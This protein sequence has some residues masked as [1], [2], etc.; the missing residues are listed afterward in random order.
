MNFLVAAN[1]KYMHPLRVMLTSLLC[2]NKGEN[3]NIYF[4]YNNVCKNSVASLKKYIEKNFDCNF[5]P[6]LIHEE[7]FNEFPISHH[8]SIETY[9]R[10]LAQDIVPQSEDRV[11]WLDADMIVRKPLNEFYYQDFEGKSLVACKSINTDPQA[12]LD[13]LGC[14]QGAVYFNAGIILFNLN[15]LRGITLQDYYKFYEHNKEKIRWLDQDILN[16]IYALDVKIADYRI[17]NMQFFS[18]PVPIEDQ[19]T[20]ESMSAVLHYIGNKKPWDD[21]YAN[22]YKKYWIE[23]ENRILTPRERIRRT[24]KKCAKIALLKARKTGHAAFYPIRRCHGI[25]HE[26]NVRR[27]KRNS[28]LKYLQAPK[29]IMAIILGTPAHKNIGDSAI[30]VAQMRFLERCGF[31]QNRI[32]EVS[33]A[34]YN[35]YADIINTALE[36]QRCVFWHGGGNMGDIWPCEEQFRQRVLNRIPNLPVVI[37]PQTIDYRDESEGNVLLSKSFQIY[38]NRK[39]LTLIAREKQSFN[40]MQQMYPNAKIL[41]TPDIVLSANATDFGLVKENRNCILLCMRSD[42]ERSMSDEMRYEV[43]QLAKKCEIPVKYTDMYA[44]CTVTK[45]NRTECIRRKMQEF[46]GAKLIITDR[47]HG[48]VFAAITETPCIAFSNT[49]HK[50]RGTYEWI[51]YLPYIRYAESVEDVKQ[52]LPEL[53]SMENCKYDN[54]PLMPYF[55]QIAEVVKKYAHD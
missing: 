21:D 3:H 33:V 13:R 30:V 32:K 47:L 31:D 25:L 2:N 29:G 15:K 19:E 38:N 16:A 10:F 41:L 17:Y 14:P 52:F 35:C 43:E 23:N 53:L 4:L 49:N 45:K 1:E 8:F 26:W 50:V 40:T 34:E 36:E 27:K 37:F 20:V 54:T 18:N 11:L 55:D 5:N 22:P 44:D 28:F 12:L 7:Y 6:C 48:M 46:A 24:V 42:I 51:Q 39:H 9:Y